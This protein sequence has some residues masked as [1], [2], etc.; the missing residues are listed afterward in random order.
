MMSRPHARC[1][2][3]DMRT[4][5]VVIPL[6]LAACSDPATRGDANTNDG[7]S[8]TDATARGQ[9][10]VRLRVASGEAPQSFSNTNGF[11][12]YGDEANVWREVTGVD[13]IYSVEVT[14][15]KFALAV[16]CH[17]GSWWFVELYYDVISATK[18][19]DVPHCQPPTRAHLTGTLLGDPFDSIEVHSNVYSTRSF[20]NRFDISQVSDSSELILS[21]GESARDVY[22]LHD[23]RLGARL[24]DVDFP[25]L[26][27]DY[28]ANT[29]VPP[30][31]HWLLLARTLLMFDEYKYDLGTFSQGGKI[32]SSWKSLPTAQSRA[33]D[34][35]EVTVQLPRDEDD[36]SVLARTFEAVVAPGELSFAGE[37]SLPPPEFDFATFDLPVNTGFDLT[38]GLD[39]DENMGNHRIVV[40]TGGS[41]L[42]LRRWTFMPSREW[43]AATPDRRIPYPDL[44]AL[45]QSSSEALFPPLT[46]IHVIFFDGIYE[47]ESGVRGEVGYRR[48]ATTH[49]RRSD[50]L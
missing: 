31:G 26:K 17:W 50:G 13:G 15:G 41:S 11:V 3:P 29:I 46:R 23:V 25:G 39:P 42:G 47:V 30:N 43:L 14:P 9:L 20:E 35:Y 27:Q 45:A 2:C 18:T 6:L 22:R 34:L 24:V 32:V 4:V 44:A 37:S 40:G 8:E 10:V 28:V 33:G 1:Y 49:T 16:G 48:R 36:I 7:R 5:G 19:I 38:V 21:H 12:A